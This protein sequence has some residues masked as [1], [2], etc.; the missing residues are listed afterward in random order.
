MRR[1]TDNTPGRPRRRNGFT[2][3]ELLVVIVIIGIVASL[4]FP[5]IAQ[6]IRAARAKET[7]ARIATLSA[8]AEGY[9]NENGFYPGQGWDWKGS[10]N[11]GSSYE[12]GSQLLTNALLEW[13]SFDNEWEEDYIAP[14]EGLIDTE[15]DWT[16]K[17]DTILDGFPEPMAILY[18]P[19][20]RQAKTVK[21]A[22]D[23]YDNDDYVETERLERRYER[24]QTDPDYNKGSYES[25]MQSEFYGDRFAGHKAYKIR[26]RDRF[27][28]IGAGGDRLYFTGDDVKNWK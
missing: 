9:K 5:S 14:K 13:D 8:G 26:N 19:A 11:R 25:T 1:E 3:I 4:L 2:L 24:I 22:Y 20:R 12:T 10:Y 17:P 16:G 7:L 27:L 28:L 6:A 21:E 23:Y 15:G 18:Y